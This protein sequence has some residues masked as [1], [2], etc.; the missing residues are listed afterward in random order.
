VGSSQPGSR[1]SSVGWLP[2]VKSW[3]PAY[4]GVDQHDLEPVRGGGL[5]RLHL[6]LAEFEEAAGNTAAAEAVLEKLIDLDRYAEEPYRRL[7]SLQAGRGRTDAVKATWRQL[8]RRLIELDLDPDPATA[9]L[10]RNLVSEEP[11]A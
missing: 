4:G 8:Q 1:R 7:M 6:R 2:Q 11:A 10:Y 3:R 9:R 5:G